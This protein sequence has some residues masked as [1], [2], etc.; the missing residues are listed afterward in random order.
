MIEQFVQTSSFEDEKNEDCNTIGNEG[1][2][3]GSMKQTEEE[4]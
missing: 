4:G 1:F 3:M 2:H